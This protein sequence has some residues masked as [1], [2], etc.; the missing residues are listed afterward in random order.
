M[1]DDN[2]NEAN[3]YAYINESSL[4]FDFYVDSSWVG[5]DRSQYIS[6]INKEMSAFELSSQ[7][8]IHH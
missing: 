5:Y 2:N 4:N 8:I 7:S 6:S 1:Y 3:L